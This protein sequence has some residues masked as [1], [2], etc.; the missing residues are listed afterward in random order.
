MI[1]KKF[2]NKLSINTYTI[3]LMFIALLAGLFKELTVITIIII[4][5]EFGHFI[6]FYKYK[7]NVE[8]ID[9]YPCGG[10]THLDEKIDK[11]LNE[12]LII[13]LMGPLMQEIL[14]LFV[15]LLY[16]YEIINMQI[17]NIFKD[18]NLNILIFNLLPILPLDVSKILNTFL[19]KI[20]NFRLSYNI[21]IIIS[22]ISLILF[23]AVFKND[24][25][26]YVIIIFLIYQI[27]Y[28][29]KN[30]Y[31]MFNRFVLEKKLKKSNFIKYKKVNSIKKMYRN[32]RNLIKE[33]GSYITEYM[34]TNK[35]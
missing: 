15:F 14:F 21:N 23:F 28:Y 32:K 6:G 4:I 1:I 34:Y 20:F 25:S 24:S 2:L 22:I 27:I 26:Y 13:T 31:I 9:I 18:Y 30:R 12:E 16:K 35:K 3:I 29:F 7:W 17:F 8:K 10:I 5:H 11:S 33:N 19:N